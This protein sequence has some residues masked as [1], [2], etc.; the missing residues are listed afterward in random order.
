MR[1]K[2]PM[3]TESLLQCSRKTLPYPQ[4]FLTSGC[5]SISELGLKTFDIYM[6]LED[7]TAAG[8]L[9]LSAHAQ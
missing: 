6:R 2:N 9:P 8:A 5:I 3:S 1:L 7:N 4:R